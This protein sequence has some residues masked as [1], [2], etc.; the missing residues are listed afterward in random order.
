MP[1]IDDY[2]LHVNIP[3]RDPRE[4]PVRERVAFTE[5]K[6]VVS[7]PVK[8]EGREVQRLRASLKDAQLAHLQTVAQ[9][10]DLLVSLM[11]MVQLYDGMDAK[12]FWSAGVRAKVMRARDVL[13]KV[14]Q[15]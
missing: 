9:R 13:A 1:R 4:Q 6:P 14:G 8:A 10:D 5:P 11:E 15:R 2:P 7:S 12:Q 3:P